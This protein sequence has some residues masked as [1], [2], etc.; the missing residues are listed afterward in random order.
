MTGWV[1]S[2]RWGG[3][4]NVEMD[5]KTRY[6]R[7]FQTISLSEQALL[8]DTR[9]CIVGLGGLGG[10]V[11][12]ILARIGIGTLDLVDGDV[13]DET[14]LNRQ[15]LS[16]EKGIGTSKART[17]R[18]RVAAINKTVKVHAFHGFLNRENSREIM[19]SAHVVV[20]CLDS[21]G[22]RFLLQ[23]LARSRGIPLV[24]GAIAGI[25]GQVTVI[26]PEDPGFQ[27][28]YGDPRGHQ[29]DGIEKQLGNLPHCALLVASLQ[30]SE[31]IK[32]VLGKGEVLR[33]RLLICDLMTNT[34]EVMQ[35][36]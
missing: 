28:I 10:G 33:N 30:C 14:N 25:S 16:T 22:D 29:A 32:V 6:A 21:I 24:S 18:E 4:E 11:V 9:V 31:V 34:F 5:M 1:S 17:A 13:F 2:R 15:L 7:N 35:L 20:D 23:D 27:L 26:Y 8:A 3:D 36:I 12:E 19:G